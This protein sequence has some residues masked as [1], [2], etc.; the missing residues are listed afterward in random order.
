ML[1][2]IAT[3]AADGWK[4]PIY[5]ASTVGDDYYTGLS[6]YTRSTGTTLQL[7]PTMQEANATRADRAYDVVTKKYRWGG[8][9]VKPGGKAP[10]FDETAGRTLAS[11]RTS[12]ADLATGMPHPR[13]YG[14]RQRRQGRGRQ[15]I[16]QGSGGARPPQGWYGPCH[17]ALYASA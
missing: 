6:P 9:D 10:Y 7:V 16:L 1:D 8:A 15:G 4:R 14:A 5:W 13:R 12:M 11:V 3:N 17:A 2:I